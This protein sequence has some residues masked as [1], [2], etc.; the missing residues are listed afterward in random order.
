MRTDD[1]LFMGDEPSPVTHKIPLQKLQTKQNYNIA[2]K[3]ERKTSL[4][5]A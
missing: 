5:M 2:D 4:L 3:N 1:S